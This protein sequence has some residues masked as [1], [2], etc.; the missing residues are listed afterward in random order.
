MPTILR[1]LGSIWQ[2]LPA[3]ACAGVRGAL[4]GVG[5]QVEHLAVLDAADA[6]T[7]RPVRPVLCDAAR[8]GIRGEEHVARVDPESADAAELLPALLE[9]RAA[10]VVDLDPVVPAV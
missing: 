6:N 5:D 9:E 8:L 10:L 4:R 2:R 1:S 7:A 3:S